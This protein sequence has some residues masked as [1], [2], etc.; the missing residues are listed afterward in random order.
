[1]GV[2]SGFFARR[3]SVTCQWRILLLRTGRADHG[4]AQSE[5][6]PPK[7]GGGIG[8]EGGR[9]RGWAGRADHG[10]AQSESDP[11]RASEGELPKAGRGAC[12]PCGPVIHMRGAHENL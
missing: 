8:Q 2:R 6:D 12:A 4:S 3:R 7:A 11:P 9:E 10:S 5:S 1:M